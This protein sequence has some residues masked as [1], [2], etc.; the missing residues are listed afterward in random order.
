[1]ALRTSYPTDLSDAEWDLLKPLIP[2]QQRRGRKLVY[3]RREIVNAVFYVSR[4]GCL[5]RGLPHDF[6]PYR[7]V[8]SYYHSWR[9]AGIWQAI[10]DELR[11]QLRV[12]SGRLVTPSAA[13]LDS[14]SV[15]M[16]S[17]P[18]ERGY[19]AGKQL[20]GRKRHVLVD[21]MGLVLHLVVHAASI[22]DRDGAKPVLQQGRKRFP[23]L[24]LVWADGAYAGK[25]EA[26]AAD[27][28]GVRLSIV[29]RPPGQRGFQ[30]LPRRWI[31]ERT[32]GWL[33]RYRRLA[34]DYECLPQSSE[35]MV[36]IALI[37]LMLARLATALSQ[38]THADQQPP[39]GYAASPLPVPPLAA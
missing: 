29:K 35:T 34:K 25:L 1:M 21:S 17:Q 39:S 12:A 8:S 24:G 22:Q 28:C 2:S 26:W 15:K 6:P 31:V 30:V 20:T 16:G 36:L 33:S 3:E 27:I 5:W 37:R 18:G 11:T 14:Q 38:P 23:T 13:V 10:H 19:D 7:T 9:R 4:N 32:F